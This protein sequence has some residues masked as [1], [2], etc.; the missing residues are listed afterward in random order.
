VA[1][2]ARAVSGLAVA[3]GACLAYGS[4]IERNWF[5]VRRFSVPVLEAGAEPLRV[6]HISDL[7]LTAGQDRKAAYISGLARLQPDLVVNTGDTWSSEDALPQ[8]MSALGPLFEFPGVFIP[9][10]ND[11]YEPKM[12]NPVRYFMKDTVGSLEG[13]TR[14]P[15]S[16]LSAAMA[17]RGWLDLTHV[18]TAVSVGDRRVA[19]TGTD[20]WTVKRARYSLVAGP[21]DPSAD[22][23][24]GVLHTPEP[25]LISSFSADGYDLVLAGHT[26]GGQ[27]R[28]PFGPALTT[29]SSLPLKY[30]RWLHQWDSS[31]WLNVCAGL[32]TNPYVPVRFGCR[33]EA[34]LLTLVPRDA[35]TF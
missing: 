23:R 6:L 20:D 1:R 12:K 2:V 25:R 3:G 14:L 9:G 31:L 34:V 19:L 10:N 30:A 7:H 35:R 24:I 21:A 27:I 15:W 33:P 32:G 4:V 29:N 18:R 5:T 16:S 22:V 17:S 28:I 13:R 8:V 26:H 11:Y